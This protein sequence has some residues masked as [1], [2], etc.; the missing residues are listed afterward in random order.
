MVVIFII[1]SFILIE[2]R[3]H[4]KRDHSYWSYHRSCPRR[5]YNPYLECLDSPTNSPLRRGVDPSKAPVEAQTSAED[6]GDS[7]YLGPFPTGAR[8]VRA[9]LRYV[10]RMRCVRRTVGSDWTLQPAILGGSN[11][12]CARTPTGKL[13]KPVC[14]PEGMVRSKA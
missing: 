10:V 5:E 11:V 9:C 8:I 7:E 2:Q 1:K 13:S 4:V 14:V 6:E 3:L 12:L